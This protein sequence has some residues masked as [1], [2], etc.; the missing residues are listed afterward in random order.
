MVMKNKVFEAETTIGF[1]TTDAILGE[2]APKSMA[3][4]GPRQQK[5]SPTLVNS[6]KNYLRDNHS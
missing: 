2:K 3:T 6:S 4:I 5:S 1:G